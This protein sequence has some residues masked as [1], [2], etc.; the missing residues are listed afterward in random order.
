MINLIK[1]SFKNIFKRTIIFFYIDT[2]SG[3]IRKRTITFP[4]KVTNSKYIRSFY[5]K[6]N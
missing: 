2:F 4:Y 3:V 5:V 6:E 1:T